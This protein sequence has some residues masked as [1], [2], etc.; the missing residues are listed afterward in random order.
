MIAQ[1]IVAEPV[2]TRTGMFNMQ[3]CVPD[4]WSDEQV[5]TFANRENPSGLERGWCIEKEGHEA[6]QGSPER[7]TCEDANRI[8]Y[9]HIMLDC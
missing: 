7:V 3:V 6:L 9:V 4:A 1:Q 2:V 8:G 5:V